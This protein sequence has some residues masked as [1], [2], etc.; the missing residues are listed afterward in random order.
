MEN[1]GSLTTVIDQLQDSDVSL[2]IVNNTSR[3]TKQVFIWM[4]E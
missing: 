3:V 2:F 4:T 1:T